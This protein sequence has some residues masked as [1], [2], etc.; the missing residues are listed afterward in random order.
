MTLHVSQFY[1]I[2]FIFLNNQKFIFIAFKGILNSSVI[3]LFDEHDY[4]GI[5]N[6]EYSTVYNTYS[7]TVYTIQLLKQI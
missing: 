4:S 6:Y 1:R 3:T 5:S 2:K 7:P